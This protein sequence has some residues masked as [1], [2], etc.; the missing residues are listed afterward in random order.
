MKIEV[1]DFIAFLALLTSIYAIYQNFK[2]NQ[3][4]AGLLEL[5]KELN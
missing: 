2:T 4:Q 5:E 3:R 1:A